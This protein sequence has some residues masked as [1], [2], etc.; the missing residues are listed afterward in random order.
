MRYRNGVDSKS[1]C[2]HEGCGR[3]AA[4]VRNGEETTLGSMPFRDKNGDDHFHDPNCV[5]VYA[6]CSDVSHL[7]WH[8]AGFFW[9]EC[10]WRS[11]VVHPCK[12]PIATMNPREDKLHEPEARS[13]TIWTPHRGDGP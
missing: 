12:C 4:L 2:P 7:G 13:D 9:C 6:R 5:S 8:G 10:G 3:E 11:D 1:K